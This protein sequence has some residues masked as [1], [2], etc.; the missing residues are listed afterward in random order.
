MNRI[1][2]L[3][4]KAKKD[5]KKIIL[6]ESGDKRVLKAASFMAGEG[7]ADIILLGKKDEILSL[8]EKNG[9]SID[10]IDII[11]PLT[12]DRLGD[13][14]QAYFDARKHKGITIEDAK[15]AVTENIINYA[16]VMTELGIA[17][18]F[19]AGACHTTSIMARSAIQCLKVDPKIGTVSGAFI[20]ELSDSTMGAGGLFAFGDCAIVRK[21]SAEQLA[22]IAIAT[23]DNFAKLFGI[24]PIV[25]LLSYATK[26]SAG[27]KGTVGT[28]REALEIVNKK[29]PDILID[30]E[31]QLDSATVPEVAA[32]K[33]PDS[34][35][36]GK[37]NVLIFPGLNAGNISYKLI[38]RLGKARAVGPML[39]GLNKPCSDLSRGCSWEDVVDASAVTA[40]RA[41]RC[42]VKSSEN[43]CKC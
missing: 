14:I 3:R 27:P 40:I 19:V 33:C 7:I 9:V 41:Q 4:D 12:Y 6:P 10:G 42:V 11:D 20:I 31:L 35:V 2:A 29:R 13:I 23:S 36:G 1:L 32:I 8:A 34:S 5:K 30:G 25:A 15:K 22:G 37:A 38:Q 24:K 43:V 17:D 28:V 21:P 16:A 39:Q 18:G 26:G